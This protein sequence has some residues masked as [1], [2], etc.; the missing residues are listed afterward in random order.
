MNRFTKALIVV[1]IASAVGLTYAVTQ[2]LNM[3]EGF[4]VDPFEDEDVI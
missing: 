3:V 1:T 4:D 2:L